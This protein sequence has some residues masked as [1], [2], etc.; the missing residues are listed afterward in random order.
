MVN[1]VISREKMDEKE[2]KMKICKDC[3]SWNEFSNES[4]NGECRADR[5]QV[6]L[7]PIPPGLDRKPVMSI[8]GYFPITRHDIWCGRFSPKDTKKYVGDP[9][10]EVLGQ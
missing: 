2:D 8:N 1:M 6:L 7:V 3:E 4:N 10:V 5:P 9:P